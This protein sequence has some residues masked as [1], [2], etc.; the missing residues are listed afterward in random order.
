MVM[1]YTDPALAVSERGLVVTPSAHL[2]NTRR[3]SPGP[4]GE[5][6]ATAHEDPLAHAR[7]DGVVYK[8]A[9]QFV[10]AT[11]NCVP[12]LPSMRTF[13]AGAAKLAETNR[14]PSIMTLSGFVVPVAEPLHP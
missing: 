4:C 14:G 2:L 9:G 5:R 11:L 7:V 1:V 13:T 10:P 6:T 12:V 8:P 3:V